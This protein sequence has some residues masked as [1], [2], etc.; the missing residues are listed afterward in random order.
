MPAASWP[1]C[2]SAWSPS[3]VIAAASGWPNT[4]NTPHSSRSRSSSRPSAQ[5]ASIGSLIEPPVRSPRSSVT[6][7]P[8]PRLKPEY[9]SPSHSSARHLSRSQLDPKSARSNAALPDIALDQPLHSGPIRLTIRRLPR[10]ATKA[11]A[12]LG[13][14][15]LRL[16]LGFGPL[17]PLQDGILRVFRQHRHQP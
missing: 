5:G 10:A 16:F 17:Q 1:R 7:L 8:L 2:W 13:L 3:A 14:R 11:A 4:P 15:I 12:L 9:S 6:G